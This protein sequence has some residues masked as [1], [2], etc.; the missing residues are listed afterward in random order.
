MTVKGPGGT[1]IPALLPVEIRLFDAAGREID[2]GGYACAEGGVAI[3]EF[4]TNIDD[5]EGA[6]RLLCVDRASGLRHD[7]KIEQE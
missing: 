2:G 3:V 7:L 4:Q 5:A 6:Y 1:A